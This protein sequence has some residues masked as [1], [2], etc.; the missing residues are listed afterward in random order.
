MN[1]MHWFW[2]SL[3]FLCVGA[4]M[5]FPAWFVAA[6]A[7]V[8]IVTGDVNVSGDLNVLDVNVL[9]AIMAEIYFGDGSH[10]SGLVGF[11]DTD[12]NFMTFADFNKWYWSKYDLN[13]SFYGINDVN[14]MFVPYVGAIKDVNLG[15]YRLRAFGDSNFNALYANAFFGD[16]SHLTGISA[17]NYIPTESD[18]D[19]NAMLI[20]TNFQKFADFNKWY[21]SKYDLNGS[22]Y[23]KL[24]INA[25]WVPYVGATKDLNLNYHDINAGVVIGTKFSNWDKNSVSGKYASSFGAGNIASGNYSFVG[26]GASN[27]SKGDYSFTTGA[28]NYA[29]DYYSFA[30][31]SSSMA[32]GPNST[33]I[34]DWVTASGD[35]STAI[36]GYTNAA[37]L[38]SVAMGYGA[39]DR[40]PHALGYGSIAAGV[41]DENMVASGV[42]SVVLGYNTRASGMA[43]L[44]VGRGSL[45]IGNY[46]FAGDFNSVASGI[47]SIAFGAWAKAT[48]LGSVAIGSNVISSDANKVAL[49]LDVNVVRDL[50]VGRAVGAVVYYGDGSHLTGVSASNYI[51]TEADIDGNAIAI[52]TNFMK[53]ADFNKWY[54]GKFNSDL[55][56]IIDRNA[57]SRFTYSVIA[58][59]PYVPSESDIDY[60]AMQ[61]DTNFQTFSDFNKWYLS[62]FDSNKASRLT[63]TTIANPPWITSAGADSNFMTFADFNKWYWSKYDLNGSFYGINDVN[64]M[65]VPYVAATKDVNLGVY[66]VKA[67]GDSNYNAL[68]A[69][70]FFGDGSK[71]TGI[72]ATSTTDTN[73][74]TFSDFNK[75]YWSKYD[76]NGSFYGKL[77]VNRQFVPYAGATKDVNVGANDVYA[78]AHLGVFKSDTT[79]IVTGVNGVAFGDSTTSSGDSSLAS[80]YYSVADGKYSVALGSTNN[81]W[82]YS[83][84]A[85]G[86]ANNAGYD[87][88]ATHG[89]NQVA[90]GY[91]NYAF[92]DYSTAL[93][94]NNM[95]YGARSLAMGQ[96]S[97]AIAD[98]STAIGY[99]V[100][101]ERAQSVALGVDVNVMHDLNVGGSLQVSNIFGTNFVPYTGANQAVVLGTQ[102]L[103]ATDIRATGDLNVDK[104]L[105]FKNMA[106]V[107]SL[108]SNGSFALGSGASAVGVSSIAL[109]ASASAVG[110]NAIA[111]GGTARSN[112]TSNSTAI[113]NLAD[114]GGSWAVALGYSA[115]SGASYS[116][117]IGSSAN[118]AGTSSAAIG[119]TSHAIGEF[120]I[121]VGMGHTY[122]LYS[123]SIGK[124]ATSGGYSSFAGGYNTRANA[125]G[126]VALGASSFGDTVRMFAD[127]NGSV[128]MGYADGKYLGITDFNMRAGDSNADL[129]SIAIGYNVQAL[130]TASVALGRNVIN[131]DENSVAIGFDLNVAR[132][133]KVSQDL[134][135]SRSIN[136]GVSISGDINRVC[137]P[138]NSCQMYMDYNGTSI[139]IGG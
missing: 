79:C 36:G 61:K 72:T 86:E 35:T 56:T 118:A 63:Y 15:V 71:L 103:R 129:G 39:T 60:N 115:N 13:G 95:S 48:G 117:A 130:G 18:I 2:I 55:N 1:V 116:T 4:S 131:A 112:G 52:D 24:D 45:A 5:T 85:I 47:H 43:S 84:V 12:S 7:P 119:Y 125:L 139:V 122:G 100:I 96:Y 59:P 80:G 34:G 111:L 54:W 91:S 83:A 87:N 68:Y 104:N 105:Y 89:E 78:R 123:V 64:R 76:L 3:G 97:M 10:L 82:G 69:N 62:V 14:R 49:G 50:N 23:G 9:H 8:M 134:N 38:G 108:A 110:N 11:A 19:N 74:M 81:A 41:S 137:F 32:T 17:S 25:G 93:D 127:G 30:I 26:G 126:S 98:D 92:G 20:D 75:W 40:G 29:G 51:P 46:S 16:G 44:A 57:A 73:F 133:A 90:I 65:F 109:G 28:S 124:G 107:G 138:S 99:G 136:K 101:N 27:I 121:S 135:V 77:D 102:N 132:T 21:W 42:G 113:G 53:F 37:G 22:F 67:F 88:I 6:A 31:G 66:G 33:A 114:S 94:Y 70:V 106:G 128:A 58:N 120:S